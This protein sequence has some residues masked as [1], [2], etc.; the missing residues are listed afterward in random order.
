MK[1]RTI[2]SKLTAIHRRRAVWA[3]IKPASSIPTTPTP[4]VVRRVVGTAY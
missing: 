1:K 3:A 4:G 2:L